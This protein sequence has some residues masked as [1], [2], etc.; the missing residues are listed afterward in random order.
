MDTHVGYNWVAMESRPGV[1]MVLGRMAS[2]AVVGVLVL[3][4]L[5]PFFG[6]LLDHHFAERF[7]HHGHI[8]VTSVGPDHLHAYAIPHHHHAGGHSHV[9]GGL[10]PIASNVADGRAPPLPDVLLFVS[11]DGLTQA[12]MTLVV[13]PVGLNV[14][15][16][17]PE[18][19]GSPFPPPGDVAPTGDVAVAPPD[20]PP[21]V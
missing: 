19:R 10:F 7:P 9:H 1:R 20:K 8:Y 4:L 14:P 18:D 13:P 3:G 12:P 2:Q 5:L 6:P 17:L 15:F 16:P 11:N 21:R